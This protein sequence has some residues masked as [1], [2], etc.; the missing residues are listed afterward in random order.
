[1]ILTFSQNLEK[2]G[3]ILLFE[4]LNDLIDH[5]IGL[6]LDKLQIRRGTIL[7]FICHNNTIMIITLSNRFR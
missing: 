4:V 5:D 3:I 1:M 6:S 2:K 7:L